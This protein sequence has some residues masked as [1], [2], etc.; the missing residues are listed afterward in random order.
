VDTV[1]ALGAPV[2]RAVDDL[3]I[4][5]RVDELPF[6]VCTPLACSP[7]KNFSPR[8]PASQVGGSSF[9][10]G[11]CAAPTVFALP[12]LNAASSNRKSSN[13]ARLLRI[14]ATLVFDTSELRPIFPVLRSWAWV[15]NARSSL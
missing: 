12:L 14:A 5:A 4:A 15:H 11:R 6:V 8:G 3:V 2:C 7:A 13:R 10:F 1:L 9:A